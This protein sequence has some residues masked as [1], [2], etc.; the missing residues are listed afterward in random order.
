MSDPKVPATGKETRIGDLL[1][2][3][4]QDIINEWVRRLNISVPPAK[5]TKKTLFGR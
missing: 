1:E 3:M 2:M 5:E 4:K